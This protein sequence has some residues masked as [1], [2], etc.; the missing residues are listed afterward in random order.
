MEAI[1]KT[2][3]VCNIRCINDELKS[4]NLKITSSFLL[5][6]DKGK[7][8][9]YTDNNNDRGA[10]TMS[11]SQRGIEEVGERIYRRRAGFGRNRQLGLG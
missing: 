11:N 1:R 7:R 3:P 9:F 6:F 8:A 2:R 4:D 10:V 5:L